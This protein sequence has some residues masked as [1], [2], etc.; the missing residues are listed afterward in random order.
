MDRNTVRLNQALSLLGFCSRRQG[1]RW[2]ETGKIRV[3]EKIITTLGYK[4]SVNDKIT[5][6][7]ITRSLNQLSK[8][9]IWVYYKPRG[10][11]TTHRDPQGRPTVFDAL[12]NDLPERII[13]VGRLDLQSEG[14]LLLTNNNTFA[15]QAETSNWERHYRVRFF[16]NLPQYAIDEIESGLT[17]NGINYSPMKIKL[18]SKK[19]KNQWAYCILNEGKNREIRNIFTHYNTQVNRLI[20]VQYGFYKLNNLKPGE[21]YVVSKT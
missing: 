2:I 3:N 15:H 7:N 11:I 21:W 1:D 18:L 4:V 8:R 16:G 9:N 17:V 20:R 6:N 5:V 10:L 12:K 13:S 19:G 14:L